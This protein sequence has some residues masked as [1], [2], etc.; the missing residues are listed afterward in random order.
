MLQ[1]GQN[2]KATI[3]DSCDECKTL[4]DETHRLNN[5]IKWRETN[6]YDSVQKPDFNDIYSDETSV[7]SHIIR[8]IENVWDMRFT[9]GR[10]KL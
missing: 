3:P 7:L 5:C 10:M 2:Y 4:D 9:N 1:C 6:N 8:Q